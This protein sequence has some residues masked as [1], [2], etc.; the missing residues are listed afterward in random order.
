MIWQS[1]HKDFLVFFQ[2]CFIPEPGRWGWGE[3]GEGTTGMHLPVYRMNFPRK[4]PMKMAAMTTRREGREAVLASRP[5]RVVEFDVMWSER[6]IFL[7]LMPSSCDREGGGAAEDSQQI[8]TI[9]L[10]KNSLTTYVWSK[11]LVGSKPMFHHAVNNILINNIWPL[12]AGSPQPACSAQ[13]AASCISPALSSSLDRPLRRT[14]TPRLLQSRPLQS[15]SQPP[16]WSPRRHSAQR[17][18]GD[19]TAEV[20]SRRGSYPVDVYQSYTGANVGV[21]VKW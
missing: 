16:L 8:C 7:I 15:S 17:E 20:K 11:C 18:E 13:P 6:G 4:N 12:F 21:W 2:A 9:Q 1:Q 5:S 10:I 19:R 14:R 3:G